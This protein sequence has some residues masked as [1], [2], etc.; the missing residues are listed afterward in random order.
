[1]LQLTNTSPQRPYS[2]TSLKIY[3]TTY[4]ITL[5][6]ALNTPSCDK[7][8]EVPFVVHRQQERNTHPETHFSQIGTK[9][10]LLELDNYL[11]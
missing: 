8:S 11:R 2:R 10:T 7:I 3:Y 6:L 4:R 1:M 9:D 5:L